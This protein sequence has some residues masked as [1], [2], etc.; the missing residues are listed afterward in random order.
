MIGTGFK[1]QKIPLG[2]YTFQVDIK[3][4]PLQKVSVL[5]LVEVV[6]EI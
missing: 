3:I 4:T 5:N 1:G 6:L 2:V